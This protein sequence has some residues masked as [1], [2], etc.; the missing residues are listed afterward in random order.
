MDELPGTGG[1]TQDHHVLC[2]QAGAP[3]GLATTAGQSRQYACTGPAKVVGAGTKSRHGRAGGVGRCAA[4]AGGGGGA[5]GT[6]RAGACESG[7][8]GKEGGIQPRRFPSRADR[9]SA[10]RSCRRRDGSGTSALRGAGSDASPGR[11]A[12]ENAGPPCAP[13]RGLAGWT[14]IRGGREGTIAGRSGV[15]GYAPSPW[16]ATIVGK[17]LASWG[18]EQSDDV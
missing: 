18:G 15:K 8:A 5:R 16:R 2:D 9:C 13:P 10:C 3:P 1:S 12:M 4:R 6:D 11:C 14:V 7:G 17:A